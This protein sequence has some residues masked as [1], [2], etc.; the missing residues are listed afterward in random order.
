MRAAILFL[1]PFLGSCRHLAPRGE[2]SDPKRDILDG[3]SSV[4]YTYT[5]TYLTTIAAGGTI[6]PGG[7]AIR[8][9]LGQILAN[10]NSDCH[11]S[12]GHANGRHCHRH[13]ARSNNGCSIS[14]FSDD[15][16]YRR[17]HGRPQHSSASASA[18]A[19]CN[20]KRTC[21]CLEI[22][23]RHEFEETTRSSSADRR[24]WLSFLRRNNR[25]LFCRK[26][27]RDIK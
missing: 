24:A 26:E 27:V 21:W 17:Q 22:V 5:T 11:Y 18:S 1:L 15:D 20:C 10:S 14:R 6:P 12:W 13:S 23:K 3:V 25:C 9:L 16:Y 2:V 7:E 19:C 4:C 8:T